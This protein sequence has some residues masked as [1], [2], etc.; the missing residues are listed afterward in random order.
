MTST[1]Q[2]AVDAVVRPPRKL[3]KMGGIPLAYSHEG[4]NY[5]RQPLTFQ[6]QRHQNIVGSLYFMS[7]INPLKGGPCVIYLH[8]NASCQLEGQFLIPNLCC[9]GVFV[10]CFDF[11]GC[12]NSDGEYIS[13]GYYEKRDVEF[14]LKYMNE[15][16][17]LGPFVLWG[18]SMGAATTLLASSELIAGK[19]SDSAYTSIQSSIRDIGLSMNIPKPIVSIMG[20]YLKSKVMKLVKFNLEEVDVLEAVAKD[21]TPVIF[22]HAEDDK[23]VPYFHV[24][25]LFDA[26]P[27]N[28]D[29]KILLPLTGGHNARRPNEYTQFCIKFILDRFG[30]EHDEIRVSY[31]REM[32]QSDF[33]YSSFNDMIGE[34]NNL[35]VDE[36]NEQ[37]RQMIEEG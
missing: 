13:L 24:M 23:F 27:C 12:G 9:Y 20:S 7:T 35:T 1:V 11:V 29:D 4:R 14:L 31:A 19:I 30:I 17:N 3:Y 6:N 18:R 28:P 25:E 16:L 8:G 26:C 33:H 10:F 32:I 34:T 15:T 22:A 5:I 37:I 2:K 21:S 36:I